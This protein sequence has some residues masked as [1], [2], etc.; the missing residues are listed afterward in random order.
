MTSR[1]TQVIPIV[2]AYFGQEHPIPIVTAAFRPAKA[3][4]ELGIMR[5]G[6]PARSGWIRSP[7]DKHVSRSW[8]RKLRAEGYTSVQLTLNGRDADFR[9]EEL[10]NA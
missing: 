4:R 8:V 3:V 6:K 1:S 7:F 2:A 10:L 9:I 5:N